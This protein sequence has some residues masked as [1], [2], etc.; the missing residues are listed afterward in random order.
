MS[1]RGVLSLA[2]GLGLLLVAAA[3]S[4]GETSERETT[5]TGKA[6]ACTRF[7]STNGSDSAAGTKSRPFRTAQ[8]LVDSLRPGQT[9]CLRSGT[10]S[11]SSDEFVVRFDRAGRPGAP[12]TLRSNPGERAR[13]RGTIYVPEG[14]NHVTVSNL[15][16]EGTGEDSTFK[17]Y[18]TD[19]VLQYNDITNAWRGTNCVYLGSNDGWGTAVRPVIRGNRIHECG[20]TGDSLDHG[21]YAANA[22]G[23]RIIGNRIYN[24]AGY[25]I[26]L[27]PNSQRMLVSRNIIDGGE[28]S[29]RGGIVVGGDDEHASNGNVIEHNVIAYA[30]WYN[31]SSTWEDA[32]GSGNVVRANCLWAASRENISSDGGLVAAG[33]RV[34]D[35]RFVNRSKRDYRLGSGSRCRALL[36]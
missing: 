5:A 20:S 25:A 33:N 21:I 36:G 6:P 35:P 28:P 15:V 1:V 9:G 10:Y 13:I 17:A 34:A 19:V 18:A 30:R 7:A 12:I 11:D 8:R 27:Y 29:V 14:S 3:F 16:L 31:V 23:G 4:A 24:P 2:F 22:V 26:Q 32:V